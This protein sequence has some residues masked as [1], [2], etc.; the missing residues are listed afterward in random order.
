MCFMIDVRRLRVLRELE[1]RG[2][3]AAAAGA[4]HLTPSAVSQQLS[5]L[6]RETGVALVEPDGRRL[7]L[8]PAARV[9]LDHSDQ[10]F[11]QLERIN[12]D[13]AS[14]AEGELGT[15]TV[16]AFPTAISALVVPAIMAL[17]RRRP[18][19]SVTVLDVEAP[20]CFEKLARGEVDVAINM[21]YA[22]APPD[23]PRLE[24]VPLLDDVMDVVVPADHPVASQDIVELRQLAKDDFVAGQRG[25]PCH[26]VTMAACA[27]RGFIPAVRHR[28]DDFA[29]M[30]CLVGAGLGVAMLPRLARLGSSA[31]AVVRPVTPP[32]PA[33]PLFLAVR[34]GS[35]QAPA[36][37]AMV[38]E[39]RAAARAFGP[40]PAS[41][42]ASDPASQPVSDPASHPASD[43]GTDPAC[44]AVSARNLGE[45]PVGATARVR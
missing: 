25:T 28:T 35:R 9:L 44:A 19:L 31:T 29:A 7:R 16:A 20:A 6:A 26:E 33:R 4:L 15:V 13:L 27:A 10:L 11:A 23:D 39:L 37:A 14:V 24:R 18:R 17:H 5:A 45:A 32:V 36:V 38:A 34:R 21:S 41:H 12:A 40:D 2:T 1:A 43:A 8:T 30:F 3:V 42:P 22:G